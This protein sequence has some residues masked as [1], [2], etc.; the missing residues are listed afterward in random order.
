MFGW[1]PNHAVARRAARAARCGSQTPP[2][3]F[4]AVLARTVA[5]SFSHAPQHA[6][7][8]AAVLSTALCGAS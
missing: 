7:S 6:N 8:R 4:A 5:D 3:Q 1:L 2:P